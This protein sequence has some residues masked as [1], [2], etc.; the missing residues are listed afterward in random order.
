MPPDKVHLISRYIGGGF[1]G[2]GSVYEDLDLA[3]LASRELGQPVK[4]ALTRQQ[5]FNATVHRPAT[6]QRVRLGATPD[7]G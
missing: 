4:I 5:M 2:K 3:A 7:G 6:V 1:G